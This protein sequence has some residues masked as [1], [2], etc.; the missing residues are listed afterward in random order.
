M[1]NNTGKWAALVAILS[2]I[3]WFVSFILIA[4]SGPLFFWSTPDVYYQIASSNDL[5]AEYLAKAFML[6][7]SIAFFIIHFSL[8]E[9]A[10]PEKRFAGKI[11]LT[12]LGMFTLLS[13]I[14]YFMQIS[15]VRLNLNSGNTDGLEH[16]LQANPTS[17]ILAINMLGW[18]LMLGIASF[19]FGFMFEN[20]GRQKWLRNFHFINSFCCFMALTGF[21]LRYDLLTFPAINLGVGASITVISVLGFLIF[22][23]K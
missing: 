21:L 23:K 12:F 16:F 6:I 14:H 13:S 15:I 7:F 11:G 3:V 18:T 1:I 4:A 10:S 19:F 5:S 22:R 2:V 20:K 9:L 17:A 8:F